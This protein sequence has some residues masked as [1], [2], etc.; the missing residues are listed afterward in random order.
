M[1]GREA[2]AVASPPVERPKRQPRVTDPFAEVMDRVML[3]YQRRAIMSEARFRWSCWSRQVGKSFTGGF[4][5]IIRGIARRRD[6]LFLSAGMRQS[7]ELMIKAQQH[8]RALDILF[9]ARETRKGVFDGAT[10][11]QLEIELPQA[12]I[13]II[14]LPANPDTARGFTGD[15]FLDE[16]AVHEHDR[17]IWGAMF[18]SVSRGGGEIDVASTPRGRQNK[19][20]ELLDNDSF[21]HDTITIDDALAQGLRDVDRDELHRAMG[22]EMLYRQEFLCEF[23]DEAT[24]FLTLE[25]IQGC[26]DDRLPRY[27]DIDE[28]TKQRG[29]VLVGVDVGRHHDL[30]V[31]W[32]IE[33]VG[34][35]LWTRGLIEMQNRPFAEQRDVL[36]RILDCRCVRKV[37]VDAT[38]LGMQLAEELTDRYGEHRVE[39]HTFTANLKEEMAG[40]LR[41]KIEAGALRIPPAREIRNDLHSV[42]KSA[43]LDGHIRLRATR[44]EGSHADRFWAVALAVYAAAEP[45]AV[46]EY[47]GAPPPISRGLR[48]F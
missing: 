5:R 7:R 2:M 13:R 31:I 42:E 27:L 18:P 30:T 4:R 24:A 35:Q 34:G 46:Y 38:G 43:T 12:G 3:P 1:A 8:C 21:A 48:A 6:Q 41:V 10:Y 20:Y 33:A 22:D 11:N 47:E 45:A 29:D 25:M 17:E 28:L 44:Q 9:R 40:K 14:G 23:V 37:G 26:E 39:G 19:F 36:C 16:F 15:V 32:A